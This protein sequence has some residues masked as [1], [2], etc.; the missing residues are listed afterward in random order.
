MSIVGI[1]GF[2]AVGGIALDRFEYSQV[3]M[4]VS[5][6]LTLYA[7]SKEHAERAATRAFRRFAE[8][9]SIMS[10]YKPDSELN[11]L[12]AGPPD[13]PQLVSDDLFRVLERSLEVSRRSGGAFDITAG[14][15][16]RRWRQVREDG[17]LPWHSEL[18]A[19][20]AQTG[21]KQIILDFASKTVTL[22]KAGLKLDLG[23]IAKGY[24]C[25][26]AV[27][28]LSDEGIRSALVE[29]GGD[30]QASEAPP[31]KHSWTISVDGWKMPLEIKNQGVSTSGDTVQFVEID[32]RRYSHIVDPRT[33]YALTSQ[34]QVT[35]IARTA[36]ETDPL[37]TACSVLGE[38]ARARDLA[39]DYGAKLV[40]VTGSQPLREEPAK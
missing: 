35:V 38:G 32:G 24:A 6:E 18:A 29:A 33:G 25:C 8:L 17:R 23:G 3:H 39:R 5:V 40:F 1:I 36:F 13:R 28:V 31:G 15:V 2:L 4:G 16:I 14:P 9:D 22:H 30:L 21:W 11:R 26:E 7:D 20:K 27:K 10:D 37:A 34:L 12:S 19:L